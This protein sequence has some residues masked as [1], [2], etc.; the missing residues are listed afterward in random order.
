MESPLQLPAEVVKEKMAQALKLLDNLGAWW[1]NL[2]G[3]HSDDTSLACLLGV[4]CD[5]LV[6]VFNHCGW[7]Y[8]YFDEGKNQQRFTQQG[9]D[10]FRTYNDLREL[11]TFLQ[12]LLIYEQPQFN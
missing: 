12:G 5:C 8:D 9:F 7:S 3:D 2:F 11:K 1:Y 10:S 6:K 4:D